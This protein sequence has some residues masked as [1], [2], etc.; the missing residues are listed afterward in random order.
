MDINQ[1]GQTTP[2]IQSHIPV[3]KPKVPMRALIPIISILVGILL[4]AGGVVAYK[5]LYMPPEKVVAQMIDKMSD[6]RSIGFDGIFTLEKMSPANVLGSTVN[7]NGSLSGLDP[8]T[9][10]GDVSS[11]TL[12]F[13]GAS[14]Y[15][16]L[17]NPKGTLNLA[18]KANSISDPVDI[19][20]IMVD[21]A[22]YFKVNNI[23][24]ILLFDL[25]VFADKWISID[26]KATYGK[27]VSKNLNSELEKELKEKNKLTDDEIQQLKKLITDSGVISIK[28]KMS[29]E[30]INGIDMYHYKFAIDKEKLIQVAEEQMKIL[31]KRESTE[32]E[33][34]LRRKSFENMLLREGEIWIGKK[35]FYLHKIMYEIQSTMTRLGEDPI[36]MNFVV[37]LK[38]HNKPVSVTA[39]SGAKP[40]AEIIAEVMAKMFDP[41]N[42]PT[43]DSD[44]DGLVDMDEQLWGTDKYNS[45]SDGDGFKDGDEVKNG[46]NPAGPGLQTTKPVSPTT[47]STLSSASEL[48]LLSARLKARDSKRLADLKQIQTALELYYSERGNM[49]Y[50]VYPQPIKLGTPDYSCINPTNGF[51]TTRCKDAYMSI[52][53]TDPTDGQFYEYISTNGTDYTITARLEGKVGKLSGNVV[54]NPQGI[55]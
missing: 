34:E 49:H 50:P 15:S 4:V 41:V 39:P 18:I 53:P 35:D 25:S 29:E 48:Y 20:T 13:N 28:E 23:P 43:L 3:Q 33:K 47:T 54:A 36:K 1:P 51:T 46:Y 6:V 52:I 45:D 17:E 14:D 40:I 37:S 16:D 31:S 44:N 5:F 30:M 32:K 7:L 8:S 10:Y 24:K 27:Y 22:F 11:L 42:S 19:D 55:K 9:L 38:D 26:Y 21:R 12:G 2:T